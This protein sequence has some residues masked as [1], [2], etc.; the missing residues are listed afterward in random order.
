MGDLNER[1]QELQKSLETD[2]QLPAA[3]RAL[4]LQAARISHRLDELDAAL[5]GAPLMMTNAK[6]DPVANPLLTESRQQA[7][8]LRQVF[9]SLGV[10][11]LPEVNSGGPS[12][13]DLLAAAMK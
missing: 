7:L 2:P 10:G 12:L 1:A 4:I 5:E 6:G 9:A 11:K 3:S 8:A 13:M